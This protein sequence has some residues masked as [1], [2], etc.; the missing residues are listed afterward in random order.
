MI[1]LERWERFKD[2]RTVHNQHGNQ[3]MDKVAAATGVSKSVIS[4]LEKE[5]TKTD[6]GYR[7]VAA[8]A[9]HYGVSVDWLLGILPPDVRTPK[10]DVRAVCDYTGLSQSSVEKLHEYS[11]KKKQYKNDGLHLTNECEVLDKLIDDPSFRKALSRLKVALFEI[12]ALELRR[13]SYM[14]FIDDEKNVQRLKNAS[15]TADSAGFSLIFKRDLIDA[16]ANDAAE[17]FRVAVRNAVG[18]ERVGPMGRELDIIES[19]LFSDRM[20]WEEA[21]MK[22]AETQGDNPGFDSPADFEAYRK[23]ILQTDPGE[24]DN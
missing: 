12:V 16:Y 13:D 22:R 2:A 23:A 1:K 21:A 14:S 7:S 4:G 6:S 20:G 15:S 5:E 3:T 17:L 11:E 10:A 9:K 19:D 18:S 24:G 8:L